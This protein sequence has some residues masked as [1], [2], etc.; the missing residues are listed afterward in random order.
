MLVLK[1]THCCCRCLKRDASGAILP[2]VIAAGGVSFPHSNYKRFYATTQAA[3]FQHDLLNAVNNLLK[4]FAIR[5]NPTLDRSTVIKGVQDF[6]ARIQ[7]DSFTDT[8]ALQDDVDSVAEYLWTSGKKHAIVKRMELCS[9]LNAVIRDDVEAEIKIGVVIFHCINNR[10]IRRGSIEGGLSM[11][12]QTY[13]PKGETWRG[14]GFRQQFTGFFESMRG[15][16]YRVPGFLAT[17]SD[18]KTAADFAFKADKTHPC[19]IWRVEFDER[20]KDQPEYRVRHMAFVSKTL[21]PGESEY[22]FAPYSVFTLKSIEW[23]AD[24]HKPHEFTIQPACDNMLED[25]NLPLT[26]WY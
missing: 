14:G 23:S 8:D 26:P 22:L 17:S 2:S 24:L 20:G 13:P 4:L 9:V 21:I 12:D 5:I 10:R 6:M 16:K 11:G 7:N 19:A 3:P 25:E 1:P 15:R 18:R